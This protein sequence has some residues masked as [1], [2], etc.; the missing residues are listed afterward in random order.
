MI[1]IKT[2]YFVGERERDKSHGHDICERAQP[3]AASFF[4]EGK[5]CVPV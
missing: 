4:V 5:V 1:F 3:Y 2:Y